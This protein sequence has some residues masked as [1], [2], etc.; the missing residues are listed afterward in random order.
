[1]S[2]SHGSRGSMI[3]QDIPGRTCHLVRLVPHCPKGRS[4][5]DDGGEERAPAEGADVASVRRDIVF[6]DTSVAPT[7][8][9]ASLVLPVGSFADAS[10]APVAANATFVAEDVALVSSNAAFTTENVASL[11]R[12]ARSS[13]ENVTPATPNAAREAQNVAPPAEDATFVDVTSI[14]SPPD[15]VFSVHRSTFSAEED[16]GGGPRAVSVET[17]AS[18]ACSNVART[19]TNDAFAVQNVAPHRRHHPE[20][21]PAPPSGRV[22]RR[23]TRSTPCPRTTARA[24]SAMSLWAGARRTPTVTSTPRSRNCST[25][26]P[27]TSGLGSLHATTTRATPAARIASTHGGVRPW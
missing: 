1:M 21:A 16:A 17:E 11:S 14:F 18:F 12:D 19:A 2:G 8:A 10:A 25:P 9:S 20:A 24:Q 6:V 22:R 23:Q 15:G 26:P 3:A 5:N 7:G 4:T 13:R 27:V